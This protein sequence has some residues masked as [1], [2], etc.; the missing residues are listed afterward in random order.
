MAKQLLILI[1]VV[2]LVH[3]YNPK[4]YEWIQSNIRNIQIIGVLAVIYFIYRSKDFDDYTQKTFGFFRKLDVESGRGGGGAKV[5]DALKRVEEEAVA[6]E[7]SAA[8]SSGAL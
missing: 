2:Y 6:A 5:I 7:N 1:L 4:Y 3:V 8:T